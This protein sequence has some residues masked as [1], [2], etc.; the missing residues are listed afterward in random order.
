MD[1]RKRRP[2]I[3]SFLFSVGAVFFFFGFIEAILRFTGYEP[4]FSYKSYAIPS[5]M[6]ELDPAV[7]EKYQRFV[8]HQGFVNE[9]VYAYQPDLLY[10]YRLKPNISITVRN[11]SSAFV[12]DKLP[13]WTIVSDTAGFR[14][15]LENQVKTTAIDR[16]LYVLG[17][18]SSFGWGVNYEKTYSSLL[19]EQLNAINSSVRFKLRNLSQP[20][21]TSFQGKLLGQEL[22]EV[23]KGDWVILSFGLNDSSPSNQTDSHQFEL[24]N[25]L[26]GKT[27]WSMRQ[28][29]LFRWMKTWLVGLPEP[30]PIQNIDIG[31][32]VPVNQYRKNFESLIEQVRN[33]G[34]KPVWVSI[35]NF[36]EYQD[37]ARQT[38]GDKKIPF[39]NFPSALEP[40][41]PIVHD[42]FPD[43]FVTYF[44][45]YGEEIENDPMLV[46][47]F[48]DRCHPNEIGHGLMAE[49][50]FKFFKR[51]IL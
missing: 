16:T 32:R 3:R 49:V 42:R 23:K 35:C 31:K 45:A 17:D 36:A 10:G 41:L 21:F 44:E 24:R 27:G 46:F 20:G 8:A 18:S 1:S 51:E 12:V 25:S 33:K 40:F 2:F 28:V 29:L 48:P 13:P 15:P 14:V 11:Y 4:E 47:L 39:F 5:W 43:Q 22:K 50:L 9:D 30:P 6:E 37:T 26:V 7:L 38:A 19:V 34:A